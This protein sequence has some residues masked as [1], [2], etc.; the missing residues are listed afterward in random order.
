[1]QPWRNWPGLLLGVFLLTACQP[2]AD[3]E[4]AAGAENE[5]AE[6]SAE[7]S[8]AIPVEVAFATRG[9]V[10]ATYTGTAPV[11][12]FQDAVVIAKVA[13]EV[14]ELLAEEGD[15]VKAGQVLARLDRT[16]AVLDEILLGLV[17]A[18]P[19]MAIRG[20]VI[21]SAPERE[22]RQRA[23]AFRIEQRRGATAEARD[24]L[25]ATEK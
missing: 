3:Q 5:P 1:M 4:Q 6:E 10:F 22:N 17:P 11:E 16:H 13:G 14:R 15:V 2:E 23:R 12:A 24:M 25:I 7:E 19:D 9:D 18:Y 20:L 21:E 8:P